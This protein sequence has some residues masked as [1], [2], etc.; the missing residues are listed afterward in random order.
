M[1]RGISH[2]SGLKRFIKGIPLVG[3]TAGKLA[4]LPVIC[5]VRRFA[6]RS[7]SFWEAEYRKGHT[8]GPGSY[9]RLAEFK[10]EI[11]NEFVRTK[12]IC[13]VIE[14]GCGD[15]A[16]LALARYPEYV[17]VDVATGSI[18]R[19]SAR[20]AHDSTK[21][22]YLADA[23]P[24]GLDAFDLALSL[25]V[26]YHLVEDSVFNAYM[27]RLFS[28][29]QRYVV[30]Y[31][32]NYDSLTHALHVRHRKFTTWVDKNAHDWQLEGTVANRFP[33]D[34]SR[35]D[36]TSHADFYFFVRQTR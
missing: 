18:D 24:K 21:R 26:V 2:T 31:A 6:F 12:N 32:S 10:A 23:L 15:G 17:G 20:F 5:R 34:P 8:S 19:C 9:G 4:H 25:D 1:N 30:I 27:H 3:P 11:L 14:F 22:F 36:E 7:A 13:T 16:Q 35:P 33:Y 28:V 29:A